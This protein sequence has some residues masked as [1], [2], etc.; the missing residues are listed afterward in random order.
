MYAR[1][2]LV[3]LVLAAAYSSCWYNSDHYQ[4]TRKVHSS[5]TVKKWYQ[6]ISIQVVLLPIKVKDSNM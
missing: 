1:P 3:A 4:Q 6:D 2:T 5:E